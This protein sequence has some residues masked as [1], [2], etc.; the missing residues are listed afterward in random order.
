MIHF[1]GRLAGCLA[2]LIVAACTSHPATEPAGAPAAC[3]APAGWEQVAGA[4]EHKV[5]IFGELHGT[6]ELQDTFGRYVCAASAQGGRTLVLLELSTSYADAIATASESADPRAELL[7]QMPQH[8]SSLDGRGSEAMLSLLERLIRLRQSGRDL[9]ILPMNELAGWPDMDSPEEK[10]AWIAVQPPEKI[11]QMGEDGMAA[12]ILADS[13]GFDRTIVLVG[14]IHARK[15]T[16]EKLPGVRHMAMLIP[17]A[18]SLQPVYDGGTSW[19]I[20]GGAAGIHDVPG[21][22]MAGAAPDSMALGPDSLPV[23]DG[24][25]SVGPISASG[26]AQPA[27]GSAP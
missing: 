7:R 21:T 13:A 6:N 23:Y 27:A 14:S 15:T 20:S 9:T 1:P 25:Y 17:D 10:A 11:Q 26:P 22:N 3:N 12:R 18:I 24:Y 16:F 19:H 2:S 8:W 4:A 5:L